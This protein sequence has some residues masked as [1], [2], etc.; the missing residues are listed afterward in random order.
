[1]GELDSLSGDC[2]QLKR[3]PS[4]GLDIHSLTIATAREPPT[5]DIARAPVSP[6]PSG[7]FQPGLF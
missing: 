1:M 4:G 6:S 2:A 3:S 7:R 5:R